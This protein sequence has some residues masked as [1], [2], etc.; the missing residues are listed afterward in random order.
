MDKELAKELVNIGVELGIA[1]GQN[2]AWREINEIMD[3]AKSR[4]TTKEKE[5]WYKHGCWDADCQGD[6]QDPTCTKKILKQD[7]ESKRA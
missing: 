1:I 3:E 4:L 7:E 5:H 2:Q 6:C